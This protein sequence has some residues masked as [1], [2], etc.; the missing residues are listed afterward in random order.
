M[1]DD[2]WT[3]E[4]KAATALLAKGL[5]FGAGFA[6]PFAALSALGLYDP[7]ANVAQPGPLL[8]YGVVDAVAIL[9]LCVVILGLIPYAPR[10]I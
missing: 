9:L 6:I 3:H 2:S 1:T 4:M 7:L 10:R 5:L 8:G